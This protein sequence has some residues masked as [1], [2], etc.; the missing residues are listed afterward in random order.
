M[1]KYGL[2][3]WGGWRCTAFRLRG[4]REAE[5]NLLYRVINKMFPMADRL[6]APHDPGLA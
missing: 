3:I 2:P 6:F 4:N 5:G 1:G